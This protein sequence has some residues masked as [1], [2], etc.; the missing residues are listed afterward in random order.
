MIKEYYLYILSFFIFIFIFL[1]RKY[2]VYITFKNININYKKKEIWED[3]LDIYSISM[4][5]YYNSS[6]KKKKCILLIGGYKDIPYVW[7]EIEKYFI[8]DKIDYY[9]PRTNGSG[10]SYFQ[11][12]N[13]KDWII[14]YIEAIHIL[15]EQYET[16]DIIG[17]STGAV[18]ALYISQFKYKCEINNIFLCSPFLINNEDLLV[19][20]IFSNNIFSKILNKLFCWIIRY[21]IKSKEGFK[22]YRNTFNE[23]YSTNDYCEIFGDL[24]SET[25]LLDFIKFRPKKIIA[26]NIIILYSKQDK[27]IGDIDKQYDIIVKAFDNK[28]VDII[29]IPSNINQN[30]TNYLNCGHVMFKESSEIIEDVYLNIKKYF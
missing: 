1:Y 19:K 28:L 14:S 20:V 30:V 21:H 24:E 4:P 9:A 3:E 6:L 11:I 23:Y 29:K 26:N 27:I 8:Q 25:I 22:G 13:S 17:F 18:I 5:R 16:I 10:R 12:V 2:C 15:Q 7:N